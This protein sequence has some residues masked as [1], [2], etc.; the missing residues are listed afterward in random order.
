M[1]APDAPFPTTAAPSPGEFREAFEA[2]FAAGADAIVCVDI[3]GTLSGTIK[4]AMIARDMLLH[5]EIHIVDSRSA[6]MGT[7]LLALMGAELAA[8]GHPAAEIA[9]ALEARVPDM[10]LYVAL[11]TLEYLKKGGRITS[12]Q[13]AMGGLLSMKP[14]ITVRDG[15][16]LQEDRVRTRSK[17]RERCLELLTRRPIERAA[18]LHS[19]DPDADAFRDALVSR[20]PRRY[21]PSD[22]P[23]A[24]DGRIDRAAP[25]SR[26]HGRRGH[27]RPLRSGSREH[28][29]RGFSARHTRPVR[30]R[31]A[32]KG[33]HRTPRTACRPARVAPRRA[34]LYSAAVRASRHR[35]G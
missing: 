10:D 19:L 32:R 28:L 20:N 8:A 33:C 9:K 5:R 16:V 35:L 6:S 24:A 1:V 21:R 30:S 29:Q 18:V 4:S 14:I 12:A 7:G 23:D 13:A 22:G 15:A 26:P 2:T 25:G 34:R 11:D 3:A 31:C 27:V 17:A